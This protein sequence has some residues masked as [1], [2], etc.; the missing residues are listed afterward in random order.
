MSNL[1]AAERA[2]ILAL[3]E[4]KE[5]QLVVANETYLALLGNDTSEYRFD[6]GEGSQ[7]A[8]RVELNDM[9]DQIDS[10][11]AEIDGYYR[12]LETTGLMNIT[13]RRQ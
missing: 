12:R 11:Q 8:K 2:R 3:I 13:L 10:L 9:K 4:Q 1:T 6:S 7:R 5:A